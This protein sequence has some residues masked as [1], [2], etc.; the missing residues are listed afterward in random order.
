MTLDEQVTSLDLS[1][2]LHALGAPQTS[3]FYWVENK[4]G[5]ANPLIV[6][7]NAVDIPD[8]NF[9][10]AFTVAELGA[11]MPY[12]FVSER[13]ASGRWECGQRYRLEVEGSTSRHPFADVTEVFFAD[14]EVEV[15]AKMLLFVLESSPA[16]GLAA[17]QPPGKQNE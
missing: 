1:K 17:F 13:R 3:I 7:P 16:A 2:R 15:R 11:M 14:T 4:Q 6:G 10:S 9:Y 8:A 5:D 12:S